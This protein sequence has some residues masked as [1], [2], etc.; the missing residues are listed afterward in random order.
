LIIL[1]NLFLNSCRS[2]HKNKIE[3]KEITVEEVKKDSTVVKDTIKEKVIQE[4]KKVDKV[5]NE[6][7]NIGEAEVTGT[8]DASNPFEWYNIQ[9]GD[10]L[11]VTKI[12]GNAEFI[13][14]T[15]WKDNNNSVKEATTEVKIDKV[16]EVSRYIVN[17]DNIKKAAKEIKSITKEVK[18]SEFPF[19]Q[20]SL[21]LFILL[22]IYLAWRFRKIIFAKL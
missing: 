18:K 11:S 19:M 16:A 12:T 3:E 5:N 9:N 8:T 20:Y 2:V 4:D 15:K 22:I 7:Q 21:I 17:E 6:K 1:S 10:T 14:K 13:I